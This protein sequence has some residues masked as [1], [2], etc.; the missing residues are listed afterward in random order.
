M[1]LNV[2]RILE[3]FPEPV[4]AAKAAGVE[5]LVTRHS[6]NKWRTRGVISAPG[7]IGLAAIAAHQ[8]RDFVVS[9][10]VED[11]EPNTGGTIRDA[12]Q[13]DLEEAIASKGDG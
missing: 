11:G 1:R 5:R 6:V 2:E 3:E 10:F 4:K 8:G 12:R 13:I 9:R 7:V